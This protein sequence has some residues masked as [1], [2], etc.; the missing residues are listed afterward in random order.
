MIRRFGAIGDVHAEDRLLGA[1]LAHLA[2]AR[3]DTVLC[4]GDIVDGRGDVDACCTLL[5][6]ASALSVRGNHERWLL[7]REMR[8]LPMAHQAR[9]L[10]PKTLAYLA[11]LPVTRR[12]QTI[13]G[14]LLLCHGLGE[15]DM[16]R[17]RPHDEGYA[18][19]CIDALAALRASDLAMVVADIPTSA[20]CERSAHSRS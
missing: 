20:W 4:V 16:A 9:D 14:P 11:A 12:L 3:V 13:A 10:A 19:E 5:D 7:A 17:L 6:E 2:S 1:A 18:L 8:G 15:D